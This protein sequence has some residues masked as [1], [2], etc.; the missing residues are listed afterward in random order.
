M[1]K[2]FRFTFIMLVLAIITPCLSSCGDSKTIEAPVA[3]APKTPG[4]ALVKLPKTT[5]SSGTPTIMYEETWVKF[6]KV[7]FE[8]YG[9]LNKTENRS[10]IIEYNTSLGNWVT[11]ILFCET[12]VVPVLITAY[13]WWEPNKLKPEFRKEN[14]KVVSQK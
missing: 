3:V 2:L 13:D 4:A 14:L 12:I 5:F 9:W 8:T 10:P 6:M 11:S 7:D 1:K